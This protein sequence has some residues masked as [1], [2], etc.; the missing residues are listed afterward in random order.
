MTRFGPAIAGI[1]ITDQAG[2]ESD[3]CEIRIRVTPP[4]PK[5]PLPKTAYTVR[6]RW[7]DGMG[8][9]YEGRFSVQRVS[10]SGSAEDGYEMVVVCRAAA[11]EALSKAGRS[12]STTRPSRRS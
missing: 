6:A 2:L 3:E 1:Q 5:A 4:F 12:I 11:A 7:S 8:G 10:W 9:E